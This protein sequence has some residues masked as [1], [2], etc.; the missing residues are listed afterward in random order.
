MVYHNG[1]VVGVVPLPRWSLQEDDLELWFQAMNQEDEETEEEEEDETDT[2]KLN[3]SSVCG[4]Y[5][6]HSP[7]Y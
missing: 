3:V 7:Q 5:R 1:L 4:Y 2:S 6:I